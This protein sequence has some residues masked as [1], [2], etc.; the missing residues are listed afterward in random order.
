MEEEKQFSE[1]ESLQLINRMIHEA[2]G[3]YYESGIAALLYGFTVFICSV[4]TYFTDRK[5][6][7]FP[8]HPFY[9]LIPVFFVQAWIQ[10]KEEKK[11]KAKTFT[12]EAIDYIWL[13]FFISVFAVFCGSFAGISY[14]L[15]T[16]VLFLTAFATFLTGM[17]A[18][19][20]YHIISSFV[21]FGIAIASFFV[22]GPV[23]YLLLAATAILTWIIPGFILNATLKKLQH[24]R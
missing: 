10:Y 14:I 22:L 13:G 15:I 21:C 19:F 20:R 3:Y 1:K 8:F 18:K 4:L 16:I 5:L 17:I 6:I 7:D 11:K 9:I 23:I 2:K 24:G 12:D